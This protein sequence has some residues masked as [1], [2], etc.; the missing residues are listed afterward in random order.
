MTN[1]GNSTSSLKQ[2]MNTL[3]LVLTTVLVF[4]V[5][6]IVRGM[7]TTTT[8]QQPTA[9]AEVDDD[10]LNTNMV[11]IGC[12]VKYYN[13]DYMIVAETRSGRMWT[14][15]D[16]PHSIEA[17]APKRIII[18]VDTRG[19]AGNED[20]RAVLVYGEYEGATGVPA[21]NDVMKQKEEKNQ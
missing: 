6:A 21:A 7:Y 3:L 2:R 17:L 13:D 9:T 5:G 19:T 1:K 16:V 10:G 4:S 8:K 15:T 14:I 11:Y 20:D 18:G 12:E